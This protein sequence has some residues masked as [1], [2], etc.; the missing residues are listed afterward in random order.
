MLPANV[1]VVPMKVSKVIKNEDGTYKETVV[2]VVGYCPFYF[3]AEGYC[4]R[5][6][7]P[8]GMLPDRN[9]LP[10]TEE[11]AE[12]LYEASKVTGL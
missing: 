7:T 4:E 1:K 3:N 8:F 10:R 11:A 12:E 9:A 6:A 2:K 5:P